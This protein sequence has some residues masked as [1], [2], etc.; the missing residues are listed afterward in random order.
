MTTLTD[1]TS[2]ALLVIDV[3]NDVVSD[4]HDRDRVVANIARLVERARAEQVPVIWVQHSSESMPQGS[5]GWVYVPELVRDES[6]PLVHKTYPDSFEE[7]DLEAVLAERQVG[8]LVVAGAQTDECDRLDASRSDRPR[9]RRRS[10]VRL[11]HDPG[12]E[13]AGRTDSRPRRGAHQPLL[14]R[15]P[16][17]RA[18]GRHCAGRVSQLRLTGVWTALTGPAL[19]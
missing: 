3:R 6:E 13:R 14:A 19:R 1:R 5:D 9:P 2:T 4:A 16:G 17:A 18:S 15:A 7:T 10:G 12:P 8:R 11:P